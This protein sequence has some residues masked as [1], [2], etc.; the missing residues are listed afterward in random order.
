MSGQFCSLGLVPEDDRSTVTTCR[1]HQRRQQPCTMQRSQSALQIPPESSWWTVSSVDLEGSNGMSQCYSVERA[2]LQIG[3]GWWPI[4]KVWY[5]IRDNGPVETC[6]LKS[7]G[8]EWV[9][10]KELSQRPQGRE[11]RLLR[12]YV[13]SN[14]IN[15]L[16][17]FIWS[18]F[19]SLY[20]SLF[21]PHNFMFFLYNFWEMRF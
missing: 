12:Y 4:L 9:E 20:K 11:K 6:L 17:K 15:K 13:L 21:F 8:K 16:E 2:E 3:N 18:V 5:L 7:D 10:L 19:I 1:G 14:E